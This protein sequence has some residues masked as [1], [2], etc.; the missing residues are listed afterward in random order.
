ML[1]E[2]PYESPN[3]P[4][5]AIRVRRSRRIYLTSSIAVVSFWLAAVAGIF[6][7]LPN[8]LENGFI[9]I[10]VPGQYVS[11]NSNGETSTTSNLTI[12]TEPWQGLILL[13]IVSVV[14]IAFVSALIFLFR[15]L[16]T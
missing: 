3:A 8:S 1:P 13:V 9:T 6:L 12:T 5:S 16:R 2:N 10:R 14:S 15:A 7:F 4:G 11:T